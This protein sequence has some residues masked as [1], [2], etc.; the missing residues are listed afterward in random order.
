MQTPEKVVELLNF[1]KVRKA[2]TI[3]NC[4]H[5][6]QGVCVCVS[7]RDLESFGGGGRS[8]ITPQYHPI[9]LIRTS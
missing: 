3:L 6:V 9:D 8:S 1:G 4:F 2:R 5:N 7:W